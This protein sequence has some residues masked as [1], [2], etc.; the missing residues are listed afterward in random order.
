MFYPPD[1]PVT[2][3]CLHASC[4]G[5]LLPGE[6]PCSRQDLCTSTTAAL[7]PDPHQSSQFDQ[8]WIPKALKAAP[9]LPGSSLA[10]VTAALVL[11]E[12]DVGGADMSITK[13]WLGRNRT[14]YPNQPKGLSQW[15]AATCKVMTTGDSRSCQ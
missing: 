10:P 11:S 7:A 13:D 12:D 6:P 15:T 14:N 8:R 2:R 4:C 9:V 3:S 5:F 1:R